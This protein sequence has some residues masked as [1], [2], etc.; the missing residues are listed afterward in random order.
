MQAEVKA[1]KPST[2][3]ALSRREW[4]RSIEDRSLDT[5]RAQLRTAAANWRRI[6]SVGHKLEL[7]RENA[8]ARGPE[9]TL[10]YRNVI[11]VT[12]GFR[13]RRTKA[14]HDRLVGEPCIV[15][16]VRRKWNKGARGVGERQHLPRCLLAWAAIDGERVLCAIPTDV[17]DE[18]SLY[19][20]S[21]RA[22][23][24]GWTRDPASSEP[25]AGTVTCVVEMKV[26]ARVERFAAS[27][28]HVFSPR[29]RIAPPAMSIGGAFSPIDMDGTWAGIPLVAETEA[30]GGALR[31]QSTTLPSFDVQLARIRSRRWLRDALADMPLSKSRPFIVDEKMFDEL[32]GSTFDLMIPTNHPNRPE[33]PR[34]RMTC[35]FSK[36]LQRTPPIPYRVRSGSGSGVANC[37]H[38]RLIEMEV[39]GRHRPLPGDS[40]SAVVIFDD[41]GT[42]TLAGIFIAS[43]DALPLAYVIP[44]FDLVDPT[45][46][47]SLPEGARLRPV[48]P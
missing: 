20:I 5:P 6:G 45:M 44:A 11:H 38:E 47:F 4:S 9:L 29:P 42:C 31:D 46:Y 16:V 34:R 8:I 30:F 10:A 40:G 33:T 27:A 21:P 13:K 48:N 18:A 3:R 12:S 25:E 26:G 7:A 23:N 15:F 2:K 19:A 24:M 32:A 39:R 41:A 37:F 14:G 22:E 1:R 43:H 28:L 36:W 35:G 17:Q